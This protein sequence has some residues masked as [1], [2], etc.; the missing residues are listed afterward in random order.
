MKLFGE[1]KIRAV[2]Y[3]RHSA[4]DKQENSVAIQREQ[5][6]RF[7]KKENIQIVEHFKDEGISGL[8][9]NRPGFQEL[10]NTW[11]TNPQADRIDYILVYDASRF[12]RFQEMSEVWRWLGLCNERGIR[13]ATATRGLPRNETSVV[14]S[15]IITLDFSM[16]GE[17][18]K[19][20]SEKVAYGSIKVAEQGYSAGGTAPY[21]YSR[22][23]LSEDRERIGILEVGEHKIISNQRVTFEPSQKGEAD[24]VK[25]IFREFVELGYLP[26]EIALGLNRGAIPTA[27]DRLWTAQGIT[28]ILTNETYIGTRVYNKTW[29]K[30]KHKKRHNPQSDWVRCLN[31]HEALINMEVFHKA[32]ERLYWLRPRTRS[33]ISRSVLSTQTYVSR[34]IEQ[35]I[36]D[37][38]DDQKHY[39]RRFMPVVFGASYIL[40]ERKR[41]CF[42]LPASKREYDVILA[43]QVNTEEHLGLLRNVYCVEVADLKGASYVV[44]EEKSSVEPLDVEQLQTKIL[45]L[46]NKIIKQQVPW[47]LASPE[48][49]TTTDR[50]IASVY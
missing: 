8:T 46:V 13:L 38:S 6:E 43:C 29:G 30:L 4:E 39:I 49:I 20:L 37:F 40:N 2:A 18:S 24:V 22:V 45:E 26:M 15:F 10:F 28:K 1:D 7:A 14:D 12:G 31:A 9:A 11:V 32:Q 27:Q 19:V 35:I 33:H 44:I 42:Y 47:L 16:S 17:F 50:A 3:Y 23:L 5:V 34:F 36:T 48:T 25:R 41:T 21:G